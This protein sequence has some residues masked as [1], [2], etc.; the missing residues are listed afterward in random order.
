[1]IG[2]SSISRTNQNFDEISRTR[3]FLYVQIPENWVLCRIF[4][5]RRSSKNNE[6]NN[7]DTN[8]NND[9]NRSS[10]NLRPLFYDFMGRSR[11]HKTA[12][13]NLAPDTSCSGS[14]GVTELSG[15]EREDHE[16]SSSCNSLPYVRRKP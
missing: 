2:T 11:S 15:H 7:R 5:K 12:D 4:L 14:S 13:L 10:D 6:G 1:M 16:E 3:N 9:N 8:S